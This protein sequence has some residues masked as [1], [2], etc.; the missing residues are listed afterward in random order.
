MTCGARHSTKRS[1]SS[2]GLR[3]LAAAA[4]D[5]VRSASFAAIVVISAGCGGGSHSPPVPGLLDG[6]VVGRVTTSSATIAWR[7][8]TAEIGVLEWGAD[9]GYGSTAAD[10]I[11]TT[12]HRFDLAGLGSS[13]S[14]H[15]R[16]H[17]AANDDVSTVGPALADHEVRLAPPDPATPF[18]MA[19]VGDSG[20]GSAEESGIEAEIEAAD[21]ELVLHT[22][23]IAYGRGSNEQVETRFL[24]PYATLLDH[25][26]LYASLG[27]HDVETGNG[28][29][30]LAAVAL[31]TNSTD[32]SSHF[33]SFDW[34]PVHAVALDS[35]ASLAPGGAQLTW[36][37]ADLGASRAVWKIVFF[38]HPPY[39]S[40]KHGSNLAIRDALTPVLDRHHV[41]LVLNGHDHDYERSF[42]MAAGQ[43]ASSDAGPGY[44]NPP[45]TIFVV[46]GGG[47]QTLYPAGHSD[48]TVVSESTFHFVEIDVAG[49]SLQATAIRLDGSTLDRFAITKITR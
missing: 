49:G 10:T 3:S 35:N 15:Y 34:G 18:R 32:G 5:R 2:G 47:G 26:P 43:I 42:P 24:D 6:P 31:P 33:Y 7:T 27:N 14:F 4:S 8:G 13:P 20:A 16:I 21:P 22:G 30:L 25:V 9:T 45:G 36:L 17:L 12:D 44:V 28:A 46:T 37:D 1:N 38:H 41:D 29:P 23:D 19:A 11:P 39:S 40:S 48:F